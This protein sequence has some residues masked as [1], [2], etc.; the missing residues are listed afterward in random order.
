MSTPSELLSYNITLPEAPLIKLLIS[1][2]DSEY[3]ISYAQSKAELYIFLFKKNN[4]NNMRKTNEAP[5]NKPVFS[6]PSEK[7]SN[8]LSITPVL[9]IR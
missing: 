1:S 8:C 7:A 6:C 3:F 4:N 9:L 5:T 2:S